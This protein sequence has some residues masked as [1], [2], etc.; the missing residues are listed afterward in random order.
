MTPSSATPV[1]STASTSAAATREHGGLLGT[2]LSPLVE[3]GFAAGNVFLS[4][5]LCTGLLLVATLLMIPRY[6]FCAF[7]AC[8]VAGAASRILKLPSGM[9]RDGTLLFNVLLA[10]L[11]VAWITRGSHLG[12]PAVVGMLLIVTI[13]TLLLAAAFWHWFPAH[14]GLPPLSMAF[15]AVFGTL[16]TFFPHWAAASV[17]LDSGL[18][19]EPE[20]TPFA[21]AAFFRSAGTVLF[22]PN[23]WA[24]LSVVLALLLWSRVA[25]LNAI[26][27]FAGGIAVVKTLE[28]CGLEWAGWFAAHN[29]LLAGMALGA[30]Y[31]VPSWSSLALAMVAGAVAALNVAAVQHFLSGSGWEYLPFPFL[32]TIWSLLCAMRLRESAGS[33]RP[34]L[35]LFETPEASAA[36]D[37]ATRT[38][39]PH[40]TEPHVLLPVK[41]EV[42]VTQGFDGTLSHRGEWRHALDFEVHDGAGRPCPPGCDDDLSNFYTTGL[43]IHAPGSGEVLRVIDGVADNPPGGCNF[44]QN[45]GNYVTLRLDFGG[46]VKLAHFKQDSICVKA[47]QRVNGGDLLGQ[48]GNSGRSPVPHLHLHAQSGVE[49]GTATTPFCLT[50]YFTRTDAGLRWNFAGVP[51]RGERVTPGVSQPVVMGT[52]AHFSP[53]TAT[54]RLSVEGRAENRS[55]ETVHLLLDEA[56]RYEFRGP[57]GARLSAVLGLHSL[58]IIESGADGSLFLQLLALVMPAVPFAYQSGMFWEDR[59]TFTGAIGA[60]GFIRRSLRALSASVAPYLPNSEVRVVIRHASAPTPNGLRLVSSLQTTRKNL[61]TSVELEVSVQQGTTTITELSARFAK[62]TLRF[63]QITFEP[64]TA[65]NN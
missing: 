11:A 42:T 16:L 65:S 36:A 62:H 52:L 56:G 6:F 35:G 10:A 1:I 30:V 64:G 8:A 32:I 39:F 33:L 18:P 15:V 28:A 38:R 55:Q 49:T 41:R 25:V 47:G 12:T 19:E 4:R 63:S 17:L 13:Y 29:Y 2:L 53:G 57:H 21:V 44:A 48:C 9:R 34:N 51:K 59:V 7:A 31:F 40:R 54:Y 5:S 27:G 3:T 45:W 50:N 37:A 43:D 14:A 60:S 46:I 23:A 58:Q 22:M 26:A 20:W 61:P 24:G